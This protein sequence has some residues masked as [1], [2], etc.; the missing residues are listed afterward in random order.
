MLALGRLGGED[1]GMQRWGKTWLM[2]VVS[3]LVVSAG[4]LRAQE[5]ADF[6]ERN[7]QTLESLTLVIDETERAL[8]D[9]R[10]GLQAAVTEEERTD[11][12]QEINLLRERLGGLRED[13]SKLATGVGEAEYEKIGKEVSNLSKE[14]EDMG[15]LLVGE[16][17]DATAPARELEDMRAMR[18]SLALREELSRKALSRLD[19][20]EDGTVAEGLKAEL[21][22]MRTA[23]GERLAQVTSQREALEL[24]LQRREAENVSL[25]ETLWEMVGNFCTQRGR[26][27]LVAVIVFLGTMLVLRWLHHFISRYGPLHRAKKSSFLVR[28]IDVVYGMF[29]GAIA[30]LAA[31]GVLY[32]AGDWVLLSIGMIFV[33]AMAWT[34]KNTLPAVFEQIKLV[35]NLGPVREGE[36]IIYE[37][38]PW[39]VDSLGFY[40]EFVNPE[41]TGGVVRLPLRSLIDEHSRPYNE[42]EPWFPSSASD[43]LILSDGT[44][45]KVVSQTPEQ[46]VLVKLGGSRMFYQTQ[47]FLAL[48]PEN[49]SNNF[50][51]DVTFGIDYAHQAEVTTT[52][53]EIFATRLTAEMEA[54]CGEGGLISLKAEFK[55]AGASSLDFEVL[56][57]FSGEMASR[58][59]ALHRAIQRCCVDLCNEHGWV[60]PFTQVTVHQAG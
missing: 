16:F 44:Y 56:A 27:L 30:L 10:A 24:R 8:V 33:V 32:S 22:R 54:Y 46:V 59:N 1:R 48:N 9:K 39:K 12:T 49:L 50:R 37:G 40:C 36:R 4:G 21:E 11:L 28:V 18:D 53:R 7:L 17:N 45:G 29:S 19:D 3:C 2:V 51:I 15:R 31:F 6:R 5:D 26:N 47:A 55:E 43:W 34:M 23:W 20:L 60:I 38:L 13:F 52:I 14:L 42:K 41:L 35:L 58:Y 57:D 25:F